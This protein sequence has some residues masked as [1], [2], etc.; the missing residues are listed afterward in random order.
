MLHHLDTT[1]GT[2]SDGKTVTFAVF[3]VGF[4]AE[5]MCDFERIINTINI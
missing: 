5:V 3:T 4:I 2:D 1:T